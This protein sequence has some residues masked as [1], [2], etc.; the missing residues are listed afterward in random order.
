LAA[1]C[2][3]LRTSHLVGRRSFCLNHSNTPL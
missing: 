2:L 3:E 1:L